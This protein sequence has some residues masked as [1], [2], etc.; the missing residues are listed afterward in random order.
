[1]N[2]FRCTLSRMRSEAGIKL[3][4]LEVQGTS[5]VRHVGQQSDDSDQALG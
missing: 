1:M 5:E 3:K 2:F 4:H